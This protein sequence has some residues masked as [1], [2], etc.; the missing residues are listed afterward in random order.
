MFQRTPNFSVPA[1]NAPMDTAY[2]RSW[3]DDYPQLRQRA[4]DD[5]TSGTLYEK[6]TRR[7]HETPP[8]EREAEYARRWQRGGVNFMHSFK[9]LMLDA[10]SNETAAEFVRSQIRATVTDPAVA[11]LLTPTD[12]PIGSKRICVDSDYF[13]TFNR[14]NVTLVDVRA[15][16][17]ECVTPT[18][19]QTR[20]K[21]YELDAIVFATGYDAMTGALLNI[22][23]SGRDGATLAQC[24]SEGPKTYLGLAVAGFPNLFTI[25]GPGSPSVLANMIFAIEQHVDWIAACIGHM[26]ERGLTCIEAEPQAQHDW[27]AHV[28][29][30]ADATLFLQANSWYLGANVPGKPR[31]FMPY[32]GG[33][34]AYRDKCVA[35]AANGYEGFQFSPCQPSL[36]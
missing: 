20:D 1:R 25:T 13:A 32:A 4:R 31:V 29:A 36:P 22:D 30:V 16:P 35:V 23:I 33:V 2:E 14:A 19:L 8:A 9:D 11:A 7:A 26:G 3:K 5:T 24:W 12:H 17:I 18:G 34:V 10:R 27:A 6:S 21:H 15:A 28:N